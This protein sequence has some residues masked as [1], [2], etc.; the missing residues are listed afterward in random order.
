MSSNA[1]AVPLA[2]TKMSPLWYFK[3][4][5]STHKLILFRCVNFPTLFL[6]VQR[7]TPEIIILLI[8][9]TAKLITPHLG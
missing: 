3:V 7:F 2:P 8:L 9:F 1:N 6:F 5:F 4:T